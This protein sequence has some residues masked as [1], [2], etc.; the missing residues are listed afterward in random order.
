MLT[1]NKIMDYY[2]TLLNLSEISSIDEYDDI[3]IIN[4]FEELYNNTYIVK[5]TNEIKIKV[6]NSDKECIIKLDVDIIKI[7]WS[8]IKNTLRSEY[9]KITGKL[10]LDVLKNEFNLAVENNKSLKIQTKKE[11]IAKI[12]EL[13]LIEDPENKFNAFWTN[14]Y[15]YLGIDVSKYPENKLLWKNKCNKLKLNTAKKYYEYVEKNNDMPKM[16]EQI[17]KITNL[18][19]ELEDDIMF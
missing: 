4:Q 15:D 8:L 1:L 18:I 2:K 19:A 3:N 16:P 11:Y 17:Y 13:N 5:E 7:D 12:N 6:F 9:I 14:W 10:E